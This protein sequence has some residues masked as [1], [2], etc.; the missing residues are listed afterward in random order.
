MTSLHQKGIPPSHETTQ[1]GEFWLGW[2]C[3]GSPTTHDHLQ[4]IYP[5]C[6]NVLGNLLYKIYKL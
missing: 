6:N 4:P 3:S 5:S 2:G 1:W